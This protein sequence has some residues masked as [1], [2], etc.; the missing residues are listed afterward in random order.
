MKL[1][2]VITTA[3]ICLVITYIPVAAGERFQEQVAMQI[4]STVSD[5]TYS[6]AEIITSARKNKVKVVILGE[7]DLMKWE[8]GVWPLRGLLKKTVEEKSLLKY[9]AERYLEEMRRL[10]LENPD[11]LIIPGVESAPFY[12]WS[13]S[14]F[15]GDLKINDWHRHLLAFGFKNSRQYENLP[16]I[17]NWRGL[18]APFGVGPVVPF[19]LGILGT[20]FIIRFRKAMRTGGLLVLFA[21]VLLILNGSLVPLRYDQYRGDRGIIPYKNYI[22][23]ADRHGA[24]TFWTHPESVY[25]DRVNSVGVETGDY[26]DLLLRIDSYTGFFI[27]HEGYAR[28]G[29]P[30]GIWDT[31]LGDYC[32]GRRARPV[33]AAA[34]LAVDAGG[35][36][37]GLKGLRTVVFLDAFT[38]ESVLEAMRRGRMYVARG[39][40]AGDF[41]LD[42]FSLAG[43]NGKAGMGE[44]ASAKSSLTVTIKG[45]LL[46][47]AN[48]PCQI[49]LIRNGK[50]VRVI[51]TGG[52]EFSELH[53]DDELPEGRGYYRAEINAAG[54]GVITNPVFYNFSG[55]SSSAAGSNL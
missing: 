41:I 24:V 11:M 49:K 32:T 44:E 7:R 31:I 45:R 21:S 4:S 50:V 47:G 55:R 15:T 3:F 53:R 18:V 36:D 13:G 6:L 29:L 40:D 42:E 1:F 43:A 28:I 46:R 39:K 5:G 12:Y 37:A 9:G 22:D 52:A 8:Y 2:G 48:G 14:P 10:Q 54:A 38:A 34:G 25:R 16:V 51:D 17:G 27:F 19:L 33:W 30:G 35:L 23:Y 20:V 26:S